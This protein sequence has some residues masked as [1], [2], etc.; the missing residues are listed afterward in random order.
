MAVV[1]KRAKEARERARRGAE[2]RARSSG[3]TQA[4]ATDGEQQTQAREKRLIEDAL[5]KVAGRERAKLS[6][7]R[8]KKALQ[9]LRLRAEIFH[10]KAVDDVFQLTR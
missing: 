6:E 1:Q 4:R 5:R 2:A 8:A 3:D 9:N 10:G 7:S